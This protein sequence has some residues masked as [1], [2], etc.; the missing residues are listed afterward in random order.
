LPDSSWF[1]LW[2]QGTGNFALN[3]LMTA[4]YNNYNNPVQ[5][6]YYN[7]N[8]TVYT[9]G[10]NYYFYYQ[11]FDPAAVQETQVQEDMT[12]FPVPTRETLHIKWKASGDRVG[13]TLVNASGQTVHSETLHRTRGTEQIS[14]NGLAPGIYWVSVS[15]SRGQ[16]I[17]RAP[18]VKL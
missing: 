5:M 7:V 9:N 15:N 6:R 8:D 16:L 3:Q 17:Y 2:D 11:D 12:L 10:Y 18:V 14:V 4:S 1:F 13:I